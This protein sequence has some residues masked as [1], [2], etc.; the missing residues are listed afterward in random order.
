MCT[1]TVVTVVFNDV[2]RIVETVQSVTAQKIEGLQHIIIDGQS[3]DGT[4]SMLENYQHLEIVSEPD[5]GIFDAM[6]K[7]LAKAVNDYVIF[8]NAGDT[9]YNEN[10][11]TD[12][13]NY[14][15]N[16]HG[17]R[18]DM[19][20][21]DSW[22]F[23]R[24]NVGWGQFKKSRNIAM[25]N[26]GM[27]CHHQAIFYSVKFLKIKK[28]NYDLSYL[29]A[30]DYAFTAEVIKN[31]NNVLRLPIC[32]CKYDLFGVSQTCYAF[33]FT[34]PRRVKVE[35][36]QLHIFIVYLITSFQKVLNFIKLKSPNTYHFIRYKIVFWC[37]R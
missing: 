5:N 24:R 6:N 37:K 15:N 25:I 36:L 29:K 32:I 16:L 7:G 30:G 14:I 20:F 4:L 2:H 33:D 13:R 17:Q 9:F 12:V 10:V 28:I 19:I 26:Y 22:E 1:F 18:P 23:D 3:T 8:M 34:E 31:S 27:I 35:I 21:G 11:L